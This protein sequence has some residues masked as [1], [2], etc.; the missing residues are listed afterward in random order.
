MF[1]PNSMRQ[2][3][4]QHKCVRCYTSAAKRSVLRQDLSK[5][6]THQY[7][8]AKPG[9]SRVYVW[10]M[11]ATG[12]L[13]VQTSVKKQAKAYADYVQHPSRLNFA[14]NR[15]ILDVAAGYGFSAFA[16]SCQGGQSL[17]GTGINTDSQIGYHKLG[18]KHRKPFELL[19][20]PAPINLS[21]V[22]GN[23]KGV[24]I[25][26]VAA[27]RAHTLALA[28]NGSVYALGNNAYGQCG[29]S[30][31]K[32]EDYFHAPLINRIDQLNNER[33]K[34]VDC[35][36]D[37]SFFLTE[38]GKLYSCGW[39]DDGQTG[40]EKFGLISIPAPVEGDVKGEQIVKVT[41]TADTVLALNENGEVFGWGNTEYGQLN[42]DGEENPQITSPRNIGFLKDCGKIVDIAAGGSYC[43]VLN[44]QGD[45][46]VW[47]YGI[48]G[49]GPEVIHKSRPCRI[50]P[51]LFGR[52][53]FNPSCRI[54]SIYAG[55]THSGAI[56][57]QD[58]LY[59]WGHN[60]HGCLGFG[61]K[62]DQFFPL[63]VAVN[64]RVLKI[65]CGVDH[66]LAL[67]KAFV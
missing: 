54:R 55:V 45:V 57:D 16:A 50:P 15:D 30:I 3:F 32:N 42:V 17:W 33:V 22:A 47:G 12:A 11:A 6:P 31:I 20:Y 58:D 46:F 23:N 7:P 4:C 49:F 60:R 52:N 48:L 38:S 40:Q 39:S 35:G 27:G 43:L 29:R 24:K 41:G 37:H 19:I 51:T 9:D 28:Q 13:G 44:D 14:E 64:A 63:K 53:D 10:G 18:G 62:K 36:Q 56:N 25:V 21:A 34:D 1:S 2:L 65:S 26:K 8:I 59:M 66:T 61:N 5:I 67:C